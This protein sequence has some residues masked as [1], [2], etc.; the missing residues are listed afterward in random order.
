MYLKIK[1]FFFNSFVYLGIHL[2]YI[3]E[4]KLHYIM[5]VPALVLCFLLAVN[6]SIIF[7]IIS[8]KFRDIP[9]LVQI[10]FK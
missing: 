5:L 10:L 7:G 6:I 8:L 1:L 9:P 4:I 2:I 3:G